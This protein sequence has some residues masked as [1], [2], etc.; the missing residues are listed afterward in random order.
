MFPD[1]CPWP[2][3]SLTARRGIPESVGPGSWLPAAF[4]HGT[5]K[6]ANGFVS[7]EVDAALRRLDRLQCAQR[8]DES[9]VKR[10]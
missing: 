10:R 6:S 4:R 8:P 3:N 9:V 5:T 2:P 7:V 1:A